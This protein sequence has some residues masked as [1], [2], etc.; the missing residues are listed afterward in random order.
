MEEINNLMAP[1]I[2]EPTPIH[3]IR[4][5]HRPDII[6]LWLFHKEKLDSDGK[7]VKDKC[8]IVN[9]SQVRDIPRLDKLTLQR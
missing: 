4:P 2:M 5:E 7:F 1:G 9:L 3:L 8:R 6:N